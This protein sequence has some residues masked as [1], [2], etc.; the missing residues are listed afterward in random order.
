[1]LS[2]LR[3]MRMMRMMMTT[4]VPPMPHPGSDGE[5]TAE[6]VVK[7][8][9]RDDNSVRSVELI[10]GAGLLAL[11]HLQHKVKDWKTIQL[12]SP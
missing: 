12:Q 8:I 10:H 7:K 5:L 4:S 9:F 11:I 6:V 2:M 1:M 3:M